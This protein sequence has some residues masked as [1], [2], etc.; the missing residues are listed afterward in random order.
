[1]HSGLLYVSIFRRI[2]CEMSQCSTELVGGP[3]SELFGRLPILQSSNIFFLS[4]QRRILLHPGLTHILSVFNTA[5][6]FAKTP[7][8]LLIFRFLAGLGGA[9]PQSVGGAVVGDLWAPDER[10]S[11][12]SI[13]SL[14][15]LVSIL[16]GRSLLPCAEPS[17]PDSYQVGPAT[18][19][20]VGGWIAEKSE[21]Q[22]V[23]WSVSIADALLQVAG[24]V[25]SSP[26]H[27]VS[28]F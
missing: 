5:C 11:A 1:M 24:F 22:W 27:G 9:A 10:G 26:Y 15:P 3:L 2:V 18:G 25:S 21:W 16:L 13:Y 7:T 8:Q 17:S 12:M 4:K 28:P 6:A 14:A 19:P 23:F 20:L